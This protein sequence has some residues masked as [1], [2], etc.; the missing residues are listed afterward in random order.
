MT[1]WERKNDRDLERIKPSVVARSLEG[2][3]G[4]AEQEKQR[5]ILGY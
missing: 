1:F 5:G 3:K 4:R 2:R